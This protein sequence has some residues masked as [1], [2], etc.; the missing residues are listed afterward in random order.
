MSSLRSGGRSRSSPTRWPSRPLRPRPARRRVAPDRVASPETLDDADRLVRVLKREEVD[1]G[2]DLLEQL[3]R[4]RELLELQSG[5]GRARLATTPTIEWGV[6]VDAAMSPLAAEGVELSPG[7]RIYVKSPTRGRSGLRRWDGTIGSTRRIRSSGSVA[8]VRD[9]F[10]AGGN[11]G[12]GC[13]WSARTLHGD[14]SI[15]SGVAGRLWE[16]VGPF[17]IIHARD[18]SPAS[19][20]LHACPPALRLCEPPRSR[21]ARPCGGAGGHPRGHEQGQGPRRPPPG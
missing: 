10:V 17:A 3:A 12:T 15:V 11:Y 1:D 6:V 5:S 9:R 2:V 16:V 19:H 20:V 8:T 7:D 14:G 4:A 13:K 21:A 18:R